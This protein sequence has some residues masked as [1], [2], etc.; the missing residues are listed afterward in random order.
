MIKH[1]IFD[2]GGVFLDLGGKH[3]GVPNDLAKIFNIPKEKAAEIWKENKEGLMVGKE[4]PEEFLMRISIQ[5]GSLINTKEAH[6]DWKK[7]NKMEKE[8]IDWALVDYIESLKENYKIHMLTNIAGIDN[9]NSEWFD[10]IA[11]H[12]NN[13]YKSFEIGHKK[14]NKEA[15]LH[16]LEKINSKTKAIIVVHMYGQSAKLKKLQNIVDKHGLVLIEDCAQAAGAKYDGKY[17]GSFGDI[18]CLS[19]YQTKHIICGGGEYH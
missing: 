16:V 3:T 13:I 8:K 10:T 18:S 7:L 1:I 19:L 2:F 6:E 12:F 9:K 5:L 17:V 15:Y 4:T 14:P 11:K